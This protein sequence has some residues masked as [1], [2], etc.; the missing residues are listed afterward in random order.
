M[1]AMFGHSTLILA[2]QRPGPE[3]CDRWSRR[4]HEAC[5]RSDIFTNVDTQVYILIWGF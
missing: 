2:T 4:S 1:S 5:D 3:L